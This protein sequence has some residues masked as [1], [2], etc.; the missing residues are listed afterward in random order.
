MEG[1]LLPIA[2]NNNNNK[3]GGERVEGGGESHFITHQP[4]SIFDNQIKMH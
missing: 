2:N 4:Q 3:M 1:K